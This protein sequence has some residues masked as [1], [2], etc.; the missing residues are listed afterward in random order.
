MTLLES[1]HPIEDDCLGVVPVNPEVGF[2]VGTRS[3]HVGLAGETEAVEE[4]E[5]LL[6][7]DLMR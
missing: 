3:E 7:D 5:M 4:K 6:L 1:G 2:H